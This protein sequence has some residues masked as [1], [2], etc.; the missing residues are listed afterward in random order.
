MLTLTIPSDVRIVQV[1]APVGANGSLVVVDCYL[2]GDL[3]VP[4][5]NAETRTFSF[6]TDFIRRTILPHATF[7][8]SLEA[9]YASQEIRGLF[10]RQFPGEK[11]C[12]TKDQHDRL[13]KAMKGGPRDGYNPLVMGFLTS[14][15]RAIEKAGEP[16]SPV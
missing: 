5:E 6:V 13:M 14:F 10:Q 15:F 9:V 16:E 1:S 7:G 3:G 11:V 12:L 8:E 4:T 2:E